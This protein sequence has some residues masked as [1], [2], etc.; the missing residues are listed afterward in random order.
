[1]RRQCA[2]CVLLCLYASRQHPPTP[3]PRA[4]EIMR[5]LRQAV[6]QA[7]ADTVITGQRRCKQSYN[8]AAAESRRNLALTCN[9][10]LVRCLSCLLIDCRNFAASSFM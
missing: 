2:A 1:M 4:M 6:P 7:E 9:L 10:V 5:L 3:Q 8:V